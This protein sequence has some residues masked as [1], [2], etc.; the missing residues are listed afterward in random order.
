MDADVLAFMRHPEEHGAAETLADEGG[1]GGSGNA[2]L[3]VEN[4]QRSQNQIEQ[5][6]RHDAFHRIHRIALKAHQIIQRK[7]GGHKGSTQ[8]DNAQITLGVRKN[9]GRRT[10]QKAERCEEKMTQNG[11]EKSGKKTQHKARGCHL[12]CLFRMLGAQLSR[13]IIARSVAKEETYRL[14]YSHCCKGNAYRCHT[15]RVDAAHEIGVGEIVHA[16]R[17]HTDNR[18]YGHRKNHMMHR[19]MSE[20][21]IV[22]SFLFLHN[23]MMLF[24]GI[25]TCKGT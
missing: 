25:S 3:E 24:W 12:L 17:Q 6:T 8:Q 23:F 21:R 19:G 1:Y 7:R 22:V 11:D 18:W 2:Q 15:L 16:R 14:N 5:H 9:G 20:E 10:H 4:E 13:N